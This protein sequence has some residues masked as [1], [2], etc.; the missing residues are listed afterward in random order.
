MAETMQAAVM[1]GIGDVRAEQVAKPEI[2]SPDQ[3]LVKI[4]AIGICGSDM[5]FYQRGRIGH[6]V[7]TGPHILGHEAAG[8][9]VEVGEQVTELQPGDTV[10]IEPGY[11]CR[12]CEYCK[13]GRY[14]LC[15]NL[16]FLGTP[17]VD[18]A[19]CEYLVWPADFLFKLPANMSLEEGAM[20]E[21]L[22]VGMHGARRMEVKGGDSVAVLGAGPIGLTTLQ[23]ARVHGASTLV[24]TDVIPLRLQV[25][26]RL[27]ATDI[28]NASEVDVV[29]AITDL[30]G[31]HGV[32]VAFECVGIATTILQAMK[33]T[34]PGG[35]V[36]LVGMG[37]VTIDDF[38]VWELMVKELDL[39]GLF[40][41][42][43]C[44]PPAIA[45]TA[46]GQVDVKSL[47]THRFTLEETPQAMQWVADHKDEVI[48]AVIVP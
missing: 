32:D 35:K 46:S 22:A 38:P 3:A 14:N 9:V 25:A 33:M 20:M 18:G 24:V 27:G 1:Y 19:F 8:E 13:S 29:E 42:A 21:P 48:K 2:T 12:R 4:G 23:A 34:R 26:E 15:R 7:V 44:Y 37:P 17:P 5:H 28:L 39:S 43:N 11:S 36:Q 47:I 30:T 16:P 6:C 31:G 45:M 40:R 41:Y 10:A